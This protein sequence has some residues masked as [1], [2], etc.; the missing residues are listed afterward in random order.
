M[1]LRKPIGAATFHLRLGSVAQLDR[2]LASGA[3]GRAFESRRAHSGSSSPRLHIHCWWGFPF[4]TVSTSAAG[5][6]KP[7]SHPSSAAAAVFVVISSLPC[8]AVPMVAQE[9]RVMIR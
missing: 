1:A 2:A 4:K 5:V 7:G 6:F 8:L 3:R 9:A